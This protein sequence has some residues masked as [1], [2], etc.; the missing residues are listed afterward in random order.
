MALIKGKQLANE[1]I[2]TT[3]ISNDSITNAKIA[4]NAVEALQ[5]KANA[6]TTAKILDS[7]ITTAKIADANITFAKL[8]ADAV[9]T[10]SEGLGTADNVIPTALAVKEYVDSV[11]QGLDVKASVRVATTSNAT[12]ASAFEAGDSLN[13]V[14]LV[15]GDRI[16]IKNQTNQTE[17]GIYT[18][19]ASGAPTRASDADTSNDLTSGSFVFVEDGGQ[20]NTGWVL[21]TTGSITLGTTNIAFSQF[22]E[23]GSSTLGAITDVS[24]SSPGSDHV[25]RYSESSWSNAAIS[26]FVDLGDLGD[27]TISSVADNQFLRYD[28]ATSLWKNETVSI[29]STQ[30]QKIEIVGDSSNNVGVVQTSGTATIKTTEEITLAGNAVSQLSNGDYV[31]VTSTGNTG[32]DVTDIQNAGMTFVTQATGSSVDVPQGAILEV[33]TAS[34]LS[35]AAVNGL[36]IARIYTPGSNVDASKVNLFFN[37]IRQTL[38]TNLDGF[39]FRKRNAA[40]TSGFASSDTT[41]GLIHG[42]DFLVYTVTSSIELETDDQIVVTY[43]V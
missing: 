7:N 34:N 15:A 8:H 3:K 20:A 43:V 17:N 33:T 23:S 18:V 13:G 37:G 11:A 5:I 6:V 1:T 29:G 39:G 12:L 38:S 2:T 42:Q 32:I 31:E 40:A 25:L 21:T 35:N 27:V 28:S 36:K 9:V 10:Q 14:S 30:E 22:S 41:A 26:S 24:L 4:D 16:L 19:N